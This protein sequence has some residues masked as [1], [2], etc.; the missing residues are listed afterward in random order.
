MSRHTMYPP[1]IPTVY[2]RHFPWARTLAYGIGALA[3]VAACAFCAAVLI[4][5]LESWANAPEAAYMQGL[6]AGATSCGSR[7]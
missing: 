6:K 1:V 4:A 3:L 2:R 5:L 7:L